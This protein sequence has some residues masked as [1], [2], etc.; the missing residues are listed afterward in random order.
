LREDYRRDLLE[1]LLGNGPEGAR[2]D[3]VYTPDDDRIAEYVLPI[4]DPADMPIIN[5]MVKWTVILVGVFLLLGLL[6][7]FWAIVGAGFLLSV[8]SSQW[9][10]WPGAEPTYY[11]AIEL[12]ALLVLCVTGAGRFAGLDFFVH[13]GIQEFR[14]RR[15]QTSLLANDSADTAAAKPASDKQSPTA[16]SADVGADGTGVPDEPNSTGPP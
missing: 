3:D 6:T 13:W 9:P 10:G 11:Q 14:Q 2:L 8:I 7:R 15:R 16:P 1:L 12:V 5:A 4:D